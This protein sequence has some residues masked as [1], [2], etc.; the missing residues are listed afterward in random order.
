MPTMGPMSTGELERRLG[1]A[2]DSVRA[3][4]EATPTVGLVLGSGLGAFADGLSDAVRI[5]Y[6]TIPHLPSPTVSGHAGKLHIGK[7]GDVTLA[8]LQGRVHLY[9]GHE[10]ER[11]VFGVRLL[12]RLGCSVVLIT[13]A[14][15]GICSS[16]H[17]GTLML[18][19]DHINLSGKN[20]LTG[21]NEASLGPRFPDM[22]HA[23]D[24]EVGQLARD[25]AAAVGVELK[26]GVY[27]AM[28]G[29]SY[30]TPA[31]I[32][33][34]RTLGVDAVGMSTVPEVIALGHMGVRCGAVSCITNMAAGMSGAA[35]DHREVEETAAQARD[36]FV[37]LLAAWIERIGPAKG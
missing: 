14:A 10:P 3:Q 15:G 7:L 20:P 28:G 35:L 29:P 21:P 1:E 17:P 12:A 33:M 37:R 6:D 8:C 30:E 11:A 23:Y 26:E 32:R 5:P 34:L 22:T 36:S 25:A 31:E 19:S 13:N 27:V 9:E 18:I 4:C 24:P 2:C 16:F